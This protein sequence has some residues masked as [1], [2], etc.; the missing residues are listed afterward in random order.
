[1]AALDILWQPTKPTELIRS[2]NYAAIPTFY[3]HNNRTYISKCS[4]Y[5]SWTFSKNTPAKSRARLSF[6]SPMLPQ[7]STSSGIFWRLYPLFFFFF[8]LVGVE[9]GFGVFRD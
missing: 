1:M 8:W 3:F 4:S 5:P 6:S 2:S 7:S 9:V